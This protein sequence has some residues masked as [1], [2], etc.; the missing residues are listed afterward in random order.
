[1]GRAS[2]RK[3][4]RGK[5][6][7]ARAA[8][9]KRNTLTVWVAAGLVVIVGVVLVVVSAQSGD[10]GPA[11]TAPEG[12]REFEIESAS[13]VE[14]PVSYEVSPAVGGDHHPAW[15]NCGAYPE[16]VIEENAVHSLEHGAVWITYQPDLAD[17]EINN[18]ADRANGETHILVTPYEGQDAPIVL[19]AWGRQLEV[20]DADDEQVDQFLEAFLQG[21]DTPELGAPCSGGIGTPE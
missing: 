11:A 13:H 3:R 4:A 18:L 14:T 8:G 19:S 7:D 21:P 5:A 6:A 20:T 9:S 15:Q 2:N 10:D 12:T 1:M 17:P 16:P